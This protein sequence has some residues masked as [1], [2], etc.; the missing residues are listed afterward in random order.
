M[1]DLIEAAKKQIETLLKEAYERA[2]VKGTLPE[3]ITLRG[4]VEIPKD[5]SYGDYASSAAMAAARE[6]RMAP[7]I[8]STTAARAGAKQSRGRQSRA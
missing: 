5:V 3:G 8:S 4:T 7:V 6:A 1:T 2:A